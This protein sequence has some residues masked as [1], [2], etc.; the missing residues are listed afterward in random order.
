MPIYEYTCCA[1]GEISSIFIKSINSTVEPSCS[2]C[3]SKDM[4]RVISSFA[5]NK[6]SVSPSTAGGST[7]DFFRDPG[8]IGRHVEESFK[9]HGVEIPQSVK[10]TIDAARGGELPKGLDL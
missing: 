3:E 10:D 4:K 5:Y 7:L 2:R 6:G 8:N 1:C 9:K